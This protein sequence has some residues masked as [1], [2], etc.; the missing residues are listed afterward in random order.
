VIRRRQSRLPRGTKQKLSRQEHGRLTRAIEAR[1]ASARVKRRV[2][3]VIQWVRG[4]SARQIASMFGA[5]RRTVS[6][7]IEAYRT[8][9]LEALRAP[10][11]PRGRGAKP[12]P[13]HLV[14]LIVALAS[15]ETDAGQLTVRAAAK[16]ASVSPATVQKIWKQRG[17]R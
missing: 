10:G 12:T 11:K 1:S 4:S 14:D 13:Q 5:S 3:I 2:D 17:L 7:W 15:V 6:R 8:G 16:E 9:G